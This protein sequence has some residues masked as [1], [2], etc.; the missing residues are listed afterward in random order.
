MFQ[1]TNQ[2][3]N[4]VEANKMESTII[5]MNKTNYNLYPT[6]LWECNSAMFLVQV[7]DFQ[8]SMARI[9]PMKPCDM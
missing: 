8:A 2:S 3:I 6:I 1:T 9:K 4:V 7:V 5:K